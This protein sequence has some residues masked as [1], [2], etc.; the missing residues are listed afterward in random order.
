MQIKKWT[1][2]VSKLK[3]A[4]FSTS[5]QPCFMSQPAIFISQN[6][7][8]THQNCYV[9]GHN[10]HFI[11]QICHFCTIHQY[12]KR[13]CFTPRNP[14]FYVK[15]GKF[16]LQNWQKQLIDKLKLSYL[17]IETTIFVCSKLS[18][19]YVKTAVLSRLGF[20]SRIVLFVVCNY[21]LHSSPDLWRIGQQSCLQLT[22][23]PLPPIKDKV[24]YIPQN[25]DF[26]SPIMLQL[27]HTRS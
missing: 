14:Y 15:T 18:F 26:L 1:A 27:G 9:L 7:L 24:L 13:T 10:C 11:H 2:Q 21:I 22:N 4:I 12:I 5:K 8:W 16:R 25:R 20:S 6:C 19:W 17:N 23:S 3:N